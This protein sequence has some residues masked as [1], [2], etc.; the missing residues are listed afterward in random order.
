MSTIIDGYTLRESGYYRNTDR[1][2]PY[3]IAA[4]GT[5]RLIEGSGTGYRARPTV[6]RPANTTAYTAGDVV[7]A[8]AAAIELTSIGPAGGHIMITAV[9]LEIDVASVPAGMGNFRGH[10]YDATPPSA[11]ADNAAFDIPSGDRDNYLGY[12]DFGTPADLGSTLFVQAEGVNKQF[13]LASGVT[14]LWMYLQTIAAFTPAGNSEV[15][16]PRVRAISL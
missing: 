10:F 3:S 15:Y 11:L 1:S 5:V 13:K 4:D 2:G 8:T 6:T 7:G 16:R 9:D 12:I 14:S